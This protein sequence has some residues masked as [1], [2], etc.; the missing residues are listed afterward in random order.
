M[1]LVI[2]NGTLVTPNA[3]FK[4]DIGINGEHIAEIGENLK[5]DRVIDASG[6]LVTPGGIDEHVHLQYFV[7]GFNTSDNFEN[8]T[9]AAAFGGTTTVIDFAEAKPEETLADALA[10]R[11]NDAKDSVIDYSIHMSV[12]PTD[13][14]KLDQI[15]DL[16]RNGCPTFKH[17]TAYAFTLSDAEIFKSFQA[18][19]KAGGMAVVHAENWDII[20]ELINQHV[21][22]GHTHPRYHPVCRPALFEGEAA[23]K[24]LCIAQAT[25]AKTCIFHITCEEAAEKLR[26]AKLTC[27]HVWGETCPHYICL[28]SSIFEKIGNLAIC[29]PPIR[30]A[31]HGQALLKALI[32]GDIDT[33]STDH[34]P[35]MKSEK[36]SADSFN[37]APGGLSSIETRM[38]LLRGLPGLSLERWVE[39]CCANPARLMGLER[40]G[41]L[42]P[43]FDADIVIWDEKKRT[44]TSGSLHENADWSPYE[45][46]EV[47]SAP[48][49][50]I[51]RG[52]EII[53]GGKFLGEKGYGKYQ[54]RKLSF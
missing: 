6:C 28:D 32:A 45:G 36:F 17:Y 40:K 1:E 43:G 34:C 16:V 51:A 26:Q 38:M 54:K 23:G 22:A 20:R 18:I 10:R 31:S 53:S 9:K 33:V 12:L 3:V 19:A 37:K 50:V 7:G 44:I 15:D 14:N 27:N 48:K 52:R 13:M 4:A 21:S 35:F 39:V 24:I 11:I 42:L 29:S 30:E 5:G 41:H 49:T 46:R 2:A 25:S 8:G 47:I